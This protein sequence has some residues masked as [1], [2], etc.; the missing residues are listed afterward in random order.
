MQQADTVA[1]HEVVTF[2]RSR[3]LSSRGL[4]WID[5]HLL[6]SAILQ[7]HQIWTADVRFAVAASELGIAHRPGTF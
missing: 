1:H 7:R 5:A 4:G 6:A 3:R 2:V